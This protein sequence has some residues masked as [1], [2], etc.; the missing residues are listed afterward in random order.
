M[1]SDNENKTTTDWLNST[2]R[3]AERL[4]SFVAYVVY[5]NVIY[6]FVFTSSSAGVSDR[7]KRKSRNGQTERRVLAPRPGHRRGRAAGGR[8]VCRH[9]G[10]RP[11]RAVRHEPPQP[12]ALFR[13]DHRRHGAGDGG[14]RLAAPDPVGQVLCPLQLRAHDV[15]RPVRDVL[16]PRRPGRGVRRPDIGLRPPGETDVVQSRVLLSLPR[17]VAVR[18]RRR[19]EALLSAAPGLAGRANHRLRRRGPGQQPFHVECVQGNV[20]EHRETARSAVPVNK[21]RVL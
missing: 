8:R 19:A 15:R 1:I 12:H 5:R 4:E 10:S 21:H 13:G 7:S 14:R 9:E 17:P 20:Q 3:K 18:S 16:Q 2:P 6:V 11:F